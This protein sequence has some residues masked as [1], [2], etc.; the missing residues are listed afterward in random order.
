MKSKYELMILKCANSDK[1]NL[2]SSDFLK[3][4][5]KMNKENKNLV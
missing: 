2:L 1:F 3:K 5:F 4:E